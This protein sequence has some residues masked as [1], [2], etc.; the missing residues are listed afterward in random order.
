MGDE[1]RTRRNDDEGADEMKFKY[2]APEMPR[3]SVAF[4]KPP[5]SLRLQR[6]S[7]G[8]TSPGAP[9]A[10]V[11]CG[12]VG[13]WPMSLRFTAWKQPDAERKSVRGM[14]SCPG[15]LRIERSNRPSH[16]THRQESEASAV[17]DDVDLKC[18]KRMRDV[19]QHCA[20]GA[21]GLGLYDTGGLSGSPLSRSS[22]C[23]ELRASGAFNGNTS[24]TSEPATKRA[25]NHIQHCTMPIAH[26]VHLSSG[27]R[28]SNPSPSNTLRSAVNISGAGAPSVPLSKST[29]AP[30]LRLRIPLLSNLSASSRLQYR[31]KSL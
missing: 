27:G 28:H 12:F 21:V 6:A 3:S 26:P 13:S 23:S 30:S 18:F 4:G 24:T 7:L 17:C 19:V 22:R 5:W 31:L 10:P 14:W 1:V 25:C 15:G 8:G 11:V 20:A 9:V 29:H 2:K 16:R